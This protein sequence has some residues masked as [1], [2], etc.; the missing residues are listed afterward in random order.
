L[1]T[2]RCS[3]PNLTLSSIT[4]SRSKQPL[5]RASSRATRASRARQLV[6]A[7]SAE[8]PVCPPWRA[9]DIHHGSCRQSHCCRRS[10]AVWTPLRLLRCC[11]QWQPH[12]QRLLTR[13]CQRPRCDAA[14]TCDREKEIARRSSHL[15]RRPFP[16]LDWQRLVEKHVIGPECSIQ[17]QGYPWQRRERKRRR[18]FPGGWPNWRAMR[19]PWPPT[20]RTI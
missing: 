8:K 20:L 9:Q 19:A 12:S 6:R 17:R 18:R 1:T 4:R 3:K 10:L 7:P 16:G 11:T 14:R 5:L 13:H 15:L 2:V